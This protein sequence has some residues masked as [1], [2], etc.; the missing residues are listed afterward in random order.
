MLGRIPQS[1]LY[2]PGPQR[3]EHLSR[4]RTSSRGSGINFTSQD[5]DKRAAPRGPAPAGL[6]GHGQLALHRPLH[7]HQGRHHAGLRHDLGRQR[8]RPAPDAGRSSC[9]PGSNYMLSATGILN[10]TTSLELSVGP[11]RTTRSNYQLQN[12]NLFRVGGGTRPGCRCSSRTPCRRT[13]SPDFRFRGGRTRQRRPVPDRPRP[14]HE[15]EH[16]LRRAREPD[17]DLGHR[18]PP[19]SA[20]TS[21]TASSR[22]ASS[23]ASTARSTS[24]TTRTTRST[25][26]TATRTPPPASSTPTRRPTSTRCRSGATRTSS[27]TPR[28]TGRPTSRLT[29]DYG[30]RFYYM[31][32]QWDTTLQASNFLPDQFDSSQAATLFRPV[33][34]G[35]YPCSGANR[36]GMDPALVSSGV[37]P[38]LGQHRRATA[39]SAASCP[40]R[41]A[42]TAPSRPARASTTSCRTATPSRSRPA[43]GFA[44]DITGKGETIVRGGAGIFY[45]RPQGNR[46]ST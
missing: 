1:R 14:V 15:R 27:G 26:A 32:P 8:Q 9:I 33:C 41:T 19:S 12:P 20:S 10:P 38:T 17:E 22:R 2:Q 25:P 35:A 18:T 11:R 23:R 46:S 39:S 31:T 6:P 34:I 16:D 24:S 40:A 37:A 28:T 29:L 13:T 43:F 21:R 42:S 36:R 45:D 44:Y 5:P 30:V 7:E 4:R 3:A